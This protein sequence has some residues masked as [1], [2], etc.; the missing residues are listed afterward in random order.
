MF[1]FKCVAGPDRVLLFI[2]I[3]EKQIEKLPFLC[4]IVLQH[5]EFLSLEL[6]PRFLPVCQVKESE[7]FTELLYPSNV[8]IDGD[9]ENILVS[10]TGHNRLLLLSRSLERRVK[11]FS[12][13]LFKYFEISCKTRIFLNSLNSNIF[14]IY[15]NVYFC[16]F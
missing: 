13:S 2:L 10:D 1:R 5:I 12:F 14:L 7:K 11:I 9:K 16:F 15:M 4:D 6:D 8:S 3:G